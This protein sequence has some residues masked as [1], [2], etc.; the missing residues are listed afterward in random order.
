MPTAGLK[1][2]I[3]LSF[4]LAVGFLLVILSC[5]LWKVYY[6]LLVV[7]TY[8]LAPI[9]NWICSRCANPDDFV[10]SSG[11]AV[12]DLGRFCTGFLVV[13]GIV[14]VS[15]ALP[16][17]LAHSDLIQIEAMFMSIIGG[18]LIYGTIISFGMF[19]QEEQEF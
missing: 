5:A 11:A 3:A 17:V 12:L 14:T 6:P 10:E 8:V 2:I 4:V 7:A 16:I 13:M 9:P 18:L 1:T 19:F 15:A